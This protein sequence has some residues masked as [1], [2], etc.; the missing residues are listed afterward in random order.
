VT[1]ADFRRQDIGRRVLARAVELAWQADGY[2]VHL[3]TG[4]RQGSTLRFY[5]RAG[6]IRGGKAYFEIR[7]S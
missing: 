2:K 7:R 4:S 6:F 5:E 1:H 3:A